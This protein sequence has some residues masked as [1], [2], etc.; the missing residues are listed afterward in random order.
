VDALHEPAGSGPEPG[1]NGPWTL[2]GGSRRS[3]PELVEERVLEMVRSGE[4]SCGD[5]LPNEPELARLF[6]VAR[7]SVRT[8]LQ[9][10]QRIGVVEVN[11]GRGWFVSGE[12]DSP[13]TERMRD[14]VVEHEFDL[15]DVLETRIALE[16]EA[17]ALAA[18][19]ATPGQ[20]D[21]IAKLCR[22]HQD[23]ATDD[24]EALLE[25]D[26]AFHAAIVEASGNRHLQA[27]YSTIPQLIADFRRDLY[28][29][30]ELHD[31][32]GIDHN[33]IV[34]QIRRRDEVGARLTMTSHLMCT[35]KAAVRERGQAD[36]GGRPAAEV[37]T[38][39]DVRDIPLWS[40]RA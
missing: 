20:L 35:Y 19:R 7:S 14:R 21:Q 23:V 4:L 39:V 27:M 38:F 29:S 31:R 11:R 28:S 16:A 8:G 24:Q 15:L 32:S 26:E 34:V 13:T 2:N 1:T 30:P 36:G 33:Q 10:L 6:G 5:R 3:V 22:S 25:T 17:A 12:P 9:R 40:D 18:A 37:S